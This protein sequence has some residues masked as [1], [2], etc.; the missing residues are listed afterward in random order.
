LVPP[1]G[2]STSKGSPSY[3]NAVSQYSYY[4]LVHLEKEKDYE[5]PERGVVT[6][7]RPQAGLP[8]T[9]INTIELCASPGFGD[10]A[11]CV[12]GGS[13]KCFLCLQ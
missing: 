8:V 5:K 9:K 11:L 6:K 4:N 7:L 1:S 10:E 12:G 13:S 2:K 3:K